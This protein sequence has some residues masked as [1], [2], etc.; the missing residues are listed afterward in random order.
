MWMAVLSSLIEGDGL[1]LLRDH[2]LKLLRCDREGTGRGCS[3]GGELV[4]LRRC[5]RKGLCTLGRGNCYARCAQMGGLCK[6]Q[7]RREVIG[8][9]RRGLDGNGLRVSRIWVRV[10]EVMGRWW[11]KKTAHRGRC[12][13]RS[14]LAKLLLVRH[15]FGSLSL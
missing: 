12:M 7:R 13:C 15:L 8:Q 5:E 6:R 10:T 14:K 2:L 9:W 11:G 3:R 1:D 4:E